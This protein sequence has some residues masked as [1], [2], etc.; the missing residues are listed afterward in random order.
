MLTNIK[1]VFFDAGGTLLH[2]Y[3]SVGEIYQKVAAQYG[4]LVKAQQL[5]TLF[6]QEWLK[7][8]GLANLASHTSEKIERQWWRSLVHDIFT[9]VGGVNNFENFFEE[10]YAVFGSPDAWRLYPETLEVLEEIKKRKKRVAI[11]SNWDSRLFKLCTALGIHERVEFILASSVFGASKPSPE[12][13][14]E[15]LRQTA[16]K[17]EETIHVGD[18]FEDDIRGAHGVGMQAVLIDR[19]ETPREFPNVKTIRHLKELLD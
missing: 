11:I 13:F 16:L 17:P 9:Q 2:P 10:L 6:R 1:A 18:S 14:H 5:E 12:I 4:C 15:A 8:D 3:P 7:R 19:H